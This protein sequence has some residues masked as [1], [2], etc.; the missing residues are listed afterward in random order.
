MFIRNSN[1]KMVKLNINNYTTE[2]QFYKALWK[3]KYNISFS[4]KNSFNVSSFIKK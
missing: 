4:K 1:M 2:K 3:L